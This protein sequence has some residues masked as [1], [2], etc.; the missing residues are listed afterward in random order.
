[1]L[2]YFKVSMIVTIIGL[3]V[4]YVWGEYRV[5]GSGF[6]AL[7]I[8]SVLAILEVSLSFDNA[9]VN[10]M[11]L[12]KMSEVWRRRFLTWGI[13]IAVFGMR[14]LFPVSIVSI[15][16]KI[17][18]LE[19]AK[20]TLTDVYKYTFYLQQTHAAVLFFC[21]AFLMMLFLHYFLNEKKEIH[22][23]KVI[24]EKLSLFGSIQGIETAITLGMIYI[25]QNFLPTTDAQAHLTVVLSGISGVILYILIHGL[26]EWMEEHSPKTDT[27]AIQQSFKAGFVSF[28]YLELIDA[29]FSLDGVLGAFALS[30]D[31]VLITL[32]LAIGAMF[33][34][35]FTIMLVDKKTLQ[36]YIFLEHGA[37]WAIGVLAVIMLYSTIHE[38]P[39]VVTGLAGLILIVWAF[40]SSICYNKKQK[41]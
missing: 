26:S 25:F 40:C 32:G 15:F 30:K 23:I 19:S 35:S 38:V 4:S 8:V 10:A 31:V 18:V 20:I 12:E 7:F 24:E 14:L 39:E 33:V 16:A 37:H 11:K 2:K 3:I 27:N 41:S 13:I 34:R 1:M 36:Q 21:A 28:M 6:L 17:P 29:S 9:V 5:A 22:W